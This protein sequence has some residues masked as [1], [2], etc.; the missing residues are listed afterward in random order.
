MK[1]L[2][3]LRGYAEKGIEPPPAML[4]MLTGQ[5]G[6]TEAAQAG[7]EIGKRAANFTGLLVSACVAGGIAWWQ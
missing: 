7:R 4:E 1:A 6:E 3:I 2:E 5:M